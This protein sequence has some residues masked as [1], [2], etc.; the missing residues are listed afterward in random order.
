MGAT[1]ENGATINTD[2]DFV[3]YLLEDQGV[4]AVHGEAFG[5]SP[6]FRVSY[7]TSDEVL[8]DACARIRNACA[9]L[10]RKDTS[11]AA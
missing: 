2:E 8:T 3:K 1:T 10:T 4:A 11:Q 7:A 9:K 6:F 5:L